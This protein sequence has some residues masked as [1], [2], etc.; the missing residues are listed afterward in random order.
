MS[1]TRMRRIE[2]AI[3]DTD[4]RVD[5]QVVDINNAPINATELKLTVFSAAEQVVLR[6]A[7][8]A[9]TLRGTLTV[10][11]GATAVVGVDTRFGE[12][13]I[14]GDTLTIGAESRVVDVI[15][16]DTELTLTT[17]HVA[18]A[19]GVTATKAT[20]IVKPPSTT[21]LYYILWGDS[22]APANLPENT[23]TAESTD[24]IFI[25][26][27][28]SAVGSERETAAQVL[29]VVSPGIMRMVMLLG[30]ELDK[31]SKRVSIDPAKFCP[32]G[33]S[34]GELIQYLCGGLEKINSYQPYTM[35]TLNTFPLLHLQLLLDCA[36]YVGVNAQSLFAVDTDIDNW[37][38]QGVSFPISHFA[39]LMQWNAAML[40]HL[41]KVI[42]QMKMHY[43]LSGTT[44]T[45]MSTT[46][47]FVNIL[48][49]A[50]SGALFR[51][52]LSRL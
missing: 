45:Q 41:D 46:S 31:T 14:E 40:A 38:D 42:P 52:M 44:Y 3:Q 30:L 19:A 26:Q 47:R 23:E 37:S 5:I 28:V 35:W 49:N 16:S 13:L 12:D 6:D 2:A 32:L 15:T 1:L 11:A 24:W 51:N 20:R 48:Q 36:M 50:P 18:G 39:K 4:E 10:A 29:R 8:P 43:A 25:W 22:A 34:D 9:Y 21:G 33:Y 7:Y 27:V 17:A